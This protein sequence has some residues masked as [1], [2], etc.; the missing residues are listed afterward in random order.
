[1]VYG[2][3]LSLGVAILGALGAL[4]IG[5]LIGAV[6]GF[7]GG[8]LDE[9]LMRVADFVLVLPAIY[10]VLALRAMMPLVLSPS[11]VF[12]TIAVVFAAAGWP[13]PAR[14]VRA[15]LHGERRKEYAEAA[16]AIGA[17]RWR[18][19]LWHL[20]PAARGFLTTQA[21][22][23][24]P[25]F[26]LAEATLSFV[27]LGFPEATPSWGVMLQ[28]AGRGRALADA[29]WLLAPALAVVSTVLTLHLVSERRNA[30][31]GVSP[32]IV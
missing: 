30:G 16:H 28:D 3:P 21:T 20:L 17:G 5:A 6:A 23:L 4:T 31:E 22:L 27:G 10:V 8:K 12:W 25:A 9:L 24:L 19:L 13:L 1:V 15:I 29:P 26:I 18:I 11:Q 2:A 14:G 32:F 7:Y